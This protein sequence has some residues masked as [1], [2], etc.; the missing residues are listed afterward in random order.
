M[1]A[2]A[3]SQQHHAAGLVARIGAAMERQAQAIRDF[4]SPRRI[5]VVLSFPGQSTINHQSP[6][7]DIID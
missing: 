6:A 4:K 7:T 3:G 2:M 5:F 1:C